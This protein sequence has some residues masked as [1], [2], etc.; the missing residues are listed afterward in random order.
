MLVE[1]PF[2]F[3]GSTRCPRILTCSSSRPRTPAIRSPR[4]ARGRR[5]DRGARFGISVRSQMRRE[6]NELLR[7]GL[8]LMEIAG[9]QT[10]SAD[11]ELARPTL[12]HRGAACRARD[13]T[14]RCGPADRTGPASCAMIGSNV[15]K[16]VFSSAVDVAQFQARVRA[17]HPLRDLGDQHLPADE[18]LLEGREQGR[19]LPAVEERR[20]QDSTL[21]PSSR[22]TRSTSKGSRTVSPGIWYNAPPFS[23][24]P[25]SRTCWRR[26]RARRCAGSRILIEDDVIRLQHGR[27][28]MRAAPSPPW[29]CRSSRRCTSRTPDRDWGRESPDM[30][31]SGSDLQ[32]LSMLADEAADQVRSG[33]IFRRGTEGQDV[34]RAGHRGCAGCALSGEF[35]SSGRY[36]Q[37]A[38]RMATCPARAPASARHERN[39]RP[40][41]MRQRG[42]GRRGRRRFDPVPR[43]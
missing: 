24:A 22:T 4:C 30:M 11:M 6:C 19:V 17:A 1:V 13:N 42:S 5:C 27:S 28:T 12:R 31:S 40:G 32:Q 26:S 18:E 43:T 14:C 8:R 29:A 35:E 16:V 3:A 38:F 39:Q 36:A 20:R 21:I 9:R 34:L 23:S 41:G 7:G 15:E 25:S 37:R 2:H 10:R 33:E